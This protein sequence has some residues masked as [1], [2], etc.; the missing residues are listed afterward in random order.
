MSN[1]VGEERSRLGSVVGCLVGEGEGKLEGADVANRL[2]V[3][4][5]LR[6]SKVD[7]SASTSRLLKLGMLTWSSSLVYG[8]PG[9]SGGERLRFRAGENFSTTVLVIS[10]NESAV[11]SGRDVAQCQL[12]R[13]QLPTVLALKDIAEAPKPTHPW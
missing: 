7:K 11:R 3:E 10:S 5:A 6:A 2:G 8:E 9:N 4:G 12:P 13:A 1:E